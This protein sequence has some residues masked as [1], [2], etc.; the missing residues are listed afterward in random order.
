MGTNRG[1]CIGLGAGES[2]GLR[3]L[4]R[5]TSPSAELLAAAVVPVGGLEVLGAVKELL[6][7]GGPAAG[8]VSEG[9]GA[10]AGE[11]E[12]EVE[13]CAGSSGAEVERWRGSSEGVAASGRGSAV[14]LAVALCLLAALLLMASTVCS[15][16]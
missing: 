8:V 16:S 6:P 11:V 1:R 3:L 2:V 5:S 7:G 13:V 15:C 9:D 10:A 4:R 14:L 12:V